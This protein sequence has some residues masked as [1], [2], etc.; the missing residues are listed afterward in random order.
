VPAPS[1]SPTAPLTAALGVLA[2]TFDNEVVL[3][4]LADGVYYG[5]TD[6]G[7]RVWHLVGRTAT[8]ESICQTIALEYDVEASRCAKDVHALVR[9]L[10]RHRLVDVATT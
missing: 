4:N 3:L 2:T 7:A 9:D 10:L 8:L 6:V 1:I 5:L